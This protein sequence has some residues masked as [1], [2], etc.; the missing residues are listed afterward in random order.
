MNFLFLKSDTNLWEEFF[1]QKQ[2]SGLMKKV[3]NGMWKKE[4]NWKK[5]TLQETLRR[6]GATY[7]KDEAIL[8][9]A[10][11]KMISAI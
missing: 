6:S 4:R 2:I 11:N 8:H 5:K 7:S 10:A 3:D 1:L 9:K